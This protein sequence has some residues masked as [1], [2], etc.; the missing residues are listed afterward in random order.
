MGS[1]ISHFLT[2]SI[3]AAAVFSCF[4]SYRRRAL[5]GQGLHSGPWREFALT[6]FVAYLFGLAAMILW[7]D[8]HFEASDGLWGNVVIHNARDSFGSNMNLIPFRTIAN[9]LP[10]L[11]SPDRSWAVIQ[12]FGNIGTFLPLGF[13]PPLLFRNVRGK[14]ALLLGL[15]YSAGAECLQFFLGR[16][17]DVD[18]VILN[19]LGAL[20]GYALWRL[21]KRLFPGFPLRLHCREIS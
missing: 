19:V 9:Y 16:H 15:A 18:D 10:D 7:P 17:C 1:Y 21:L 20:L 2:G 11:A 14:Q 4:H 12:L 5:T 13:F 3:P 8:Y 6:V